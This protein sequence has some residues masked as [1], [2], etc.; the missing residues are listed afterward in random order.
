MHNKFLLTLSFLLVLTGTIV[1][2]TGNSEVFL[3][4]LDISNNSAS[5]SNPRNI[6]NS[7][8]Y[9]NQPSFG[10][11]S[12]SIL[13]TSSRNGILPDIYEYSI[14]DRKLRRVTKTKENEY[15]ARERKKGKITFVREGLDQT[16]SVFMIDRKTGKES[17]ALK[18]KEPVAYY[19]WNPD[20]GALVWVRYGWM[21]RYVHPEKGIN[22]FVTDNMQPSA[23][24]NIPGTNKF[25]F[26]Y[27]RP[28]GSQWIKEFDPA[29]R[30][31]RPITPIKDDSI[32]YCWTNEGTM[33]TGS[34]SKLFAFAESGSKRWE[35]ITD[36][37]DLK[38]KRIT[39]M[40]VSNS[41]KRLVLVGEL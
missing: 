27:R 9:D 17:W 15:T 20:G 38:I 36:L 37:K 41:G 4:D 2:Q 40:A 16:M 19:D 14:D 24:Q 6:S 13:F 30:S 7:P 21:G 29:T 8:G 33:I 1:A 39:R 25:T 26:V 10:F 3:F 28:D 12:N 35:E 32:D 34:G 23:P 18:N 11:D 31:V 22:S 5:L